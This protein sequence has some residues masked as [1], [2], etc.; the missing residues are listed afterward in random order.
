MTAFTV[1]PDDIQI[2]I[3]ADAL[4]TYQFGSKVARHHFL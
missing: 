2:E 3:L 4:A 1:A